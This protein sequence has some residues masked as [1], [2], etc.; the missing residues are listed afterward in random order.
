MYQKASGG[1]GADSA[2]TATRPDAGLGHVC[3]RQARQRGRAS[4]ACHAS[5]YTHTPAAPGGREPKPQSRRLQLYPL[6]LLCSSPLLFA[7]RIHRSAGKGNRCL[8]DRTSE[9]RMGALAICSFAAR[10]WGHSLGFLIG[11]GFLPSWGWMDIAHSSGVSFH[12]L[13]RS[14]SLE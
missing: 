11:G 9:S 3:A 14:A 2:S 8:I 10:S 4:L 12:V 13:S 5:I 6:F 7:G 1:A